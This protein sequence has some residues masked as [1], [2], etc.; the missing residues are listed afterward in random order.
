MIK[1][2]DHIRLDRSS[3][4]SLEAQI[5][6]QLTQMIA[7]DM[8]GVGGQ[9]P[10]MRSLADAV[11]VNLHTV[12][13]AYL[14][15]ESRGLVEVTRRRGTR[16]TARD[17]AGFV[18]DERGRSFTI[19]VLLP[20]V[21]SFYAPLVAGMASVLEGEPSSL[22][23]AFA[24]ERRDSALNSLR[25]FLAAG[26]DGVAVVS[27]TF[28]GGVVFDRDEMPPIVFGDWPGAPGRSITFDSAAFGELVDHVVA[29]G[30]GS[31]G[32]ICPPRRHPNVGPLVDAYVESCHRFGLH[33][34]VHN[35]Y[36]VPG[37]SASH[38]ATAARLALESDSRPG[39][40]LAATDELAMGVYRAATQLGLR[41]G[42]DLAVAGYGGTDVGEFL[43]PSLTTVVLPAREMGRQI[44]TVLLTLIEGEAEPTPLTL[45]GHI[46]VRG[47]CGSHD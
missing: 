33:E 19:G 40:L 47:S 6:A 36:E 38:G 4:V 14:R 25:R 28:D 20:A 43:D 45:R 21:S 29:H 18:Q 16:V 8:I 10:S 15:L 32:L 37:W 31:C 2:G 3:P 24:D 39:A 34:S 23:F 41:V 5:A 22:L 11:G 7:A 27:Q 17:L 9:L 35:V 42:T 1:P 12:R 46:E 44:M 26:V 13:A 30:H